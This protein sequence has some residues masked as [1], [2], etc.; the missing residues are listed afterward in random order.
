MY[1][2][3]T[4]PGLLS[5]GSLLLPALP[6]PFLPFLK[7][8]AVGNAKMDVGPLYVFILST[9]IG[10]ISFLCLAPLSVS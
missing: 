3:T 7:H 1:Q 8:Q 2:T 10:Y 5:Y 9:Y 4:R 6:G